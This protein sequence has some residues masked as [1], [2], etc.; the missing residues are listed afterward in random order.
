MAEPCLLA[1]VVGTFVDLRVALW[2]RR[3]VSL[4]IALPFEESACHLLYSAKQGSV[5][6]VI[7]ENSEGDEEA[8]AYEAAQPSSDPVPFLR[9]FSALKSPCDRRIYCLPTA[10]CKKVVSGR[11][12]R[13]QI[14]I[15][16][17][18]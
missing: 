4:V 8:A 15:T 16:S 18:T 17:S 11:K 2:Q 13:Q 1:A 6:K 3:C 5:D 10:V 12:L 7:S 14:H 9:A